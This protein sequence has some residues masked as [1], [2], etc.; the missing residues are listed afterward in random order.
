MT[1]QKRHFV[2]FVPY[3]TWTLTSL[4][5][6]TCHFSRAYDFNDLNELSLAFTSITTKAN[7]V[8]ESLKYWLQTSNNLASIIQKINNNPYIDRENARDACNN[9][10]KLAIKLSGTNFEL[11]DDEKNIYAF[12]LKTMYIT[13]LEY[14]V[15]LILVFSKMIK[16][17]LCLLIILRT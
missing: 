8:L 11:T 6:K 17:Q 14:I 5:N 4:I 13:T 12:Y 1:E 3:N 16:Q 2:K 9:A 10:S 7:T 15:Y